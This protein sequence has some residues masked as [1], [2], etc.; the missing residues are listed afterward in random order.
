METKQKILNNISRN[1]VNEIVLYLMSKKISYRFFQQDIEDHLKEKKYSKERIKDVM[2]LIDVYLNKKNENKKNALHNILK[3]ILIAED[4]NISSLEDLKIYIDTL[5]IFEPSDTFN[6]GG[7]H[8][9]VI[10]AKNWLTKEDL[11][12]T[13]GGR[14]LAKIGIT[15]FISHDYDPKFFQS[16]ISYEDTMYHYFDDAEV[17]NILPLSVMEV[18]T[19]YFAPKS[20]DMDKCICIKLAYHCTIRVV[21]TN[22]LFFMEVQQSCGT[23]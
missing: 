7:K 9:C 2:E 17:I 22:G 6:F 18:Y 23:P 1:T 19:K 15:E 5:S 12:K 4:S 13:N 16:C 3:P 8:V 11:V 20:V 21:K 10:D 14:D